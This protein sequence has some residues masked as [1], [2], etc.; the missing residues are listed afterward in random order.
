MYEV[1]LTLEETV[2]GIRQ[3][4]GNLAHPACCCGEWPGA[5]GQRIK[6]RSSRKI[7]RSIDKEKITIL[8]ARFEQTAILHPPTGPGI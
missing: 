7:P 5:S 4:A 3:I 2:H 1:A 6:I 8:A